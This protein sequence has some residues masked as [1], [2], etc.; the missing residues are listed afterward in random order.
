MPYDPHA[1]TSEERDKA[2]A[3]IWIGLGANLV[4]LA[5]FA[6]R[7]GPQLEGFAGLIVGLNLTIYALSGRFDEHFKSLANFGF[8]CLATVIGFWLSAQGLLTV[9]EGAYSIG[10]GIGATAAGATVPNDDF[11]IVLPA[12]M[13]SAYLL[14]ALAGAAFHAGFLF[15]HLRGPQ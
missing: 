6:F 10:E 4:M 8:L 9:V 15:Q 7:L 14:A 2:Y 12:F 1:P 13:N 3:G 11:T 5:A